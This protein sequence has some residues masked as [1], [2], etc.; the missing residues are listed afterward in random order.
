MLIYTSFPHL[1]CLLLYFKFH[2]HF[3]LSS[4]PAAYIVFWCDNSFTRVLDC[5]VGLFFVSLCTIQQQQVINIHYLL[6]RSWHS[7]W[8]LCIQSYQPSVWTLTMLSLNFLVR[9][10]VSWCGRPL[11]SLNVT[12]ICLYIQVPHCCLKV[13]FSY[14]I[15][16]GRI[17][18]LFK[19]LSFDRLIHKIAYSTAAAEWKCSSSWTSTGKH[20]SNDMR[21]EVMNL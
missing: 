13:F 8:Y 16:S 21:I 6:V 14:Y 15:I 1:I 9:V 4:K 17:S 10:I 19:G 18:W 3:Y 11:A 5:S 12:N 2:T 7:W 20:C